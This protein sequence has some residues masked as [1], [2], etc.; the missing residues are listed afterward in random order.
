MLKKI[1]QVF[2]ALL[3]VAYT[4]P[5]CHDPTELGC[6]SP[7]RADSHVQQMQKLISY[8]DRHHDAEQVMVEDRRWTSDEGSPS[9]WSSDDSRFDDSRAVSL[10]GHP[11]D[12]LSYA[13]YDAPAYFQL[14]G[15]Y[16]GAQIMWA[17][18][19]SAALREA[20]IPA[21]YTGSTLGGQKAYS[22]MY[23]E[24]REN[25]FAEDC[26]HPD[27]SSDGSESDSYLRSD[28]IIVGAGRTTANA[29]S[30]ITHE[31][32]FN[33]RYNPFLDLSRMK[34]EGELADGRGEAS[35]VSRGQNLEWDQ[36][37]NAAVSTGFQPWR[38]PMNVPK[39]PAPAK[40]KPSFSD[41]LKKVNTPVKNP[42][43]KLD[44]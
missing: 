17:W 1:G 29:G 2:F 14:C 23:S 33:W 32:F 36:D 7:L 41:V 38:Q 34:Q 19:P 24:F 37:V 13:L 42:M 18:V 21:F 10:G 5:L 35:L 20:L 44:V 31:L 39:E 43:L 3:S 4:T 16:D 27:V 28:R 15:F 25:T 22:N 8:L 6:D 40:I 26:T 30:P 12:T 11:T 9:G